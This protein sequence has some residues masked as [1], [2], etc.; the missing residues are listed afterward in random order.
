MKIWS[1]AFCFLN[2]YC[3]NHPLGSDGAREV[4]APFILVW[5]VEFRGTFWELNALVIICSLVRVLLWFWYPFILKKSWSYPI[6]ATGHCCLP[7][8]FCLVNI[9]TGSEIWLIRKKKKKFQL[10]N[11]KERNQGIN[12]YGYFFFLIY[13][14][15]LYHKGEV[16]WE[17]IY[18]VSSGATQWSADFLLCFY[19]PGAMNVLS[20]YFY[21]T[22]WKYTTKE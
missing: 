13:T 17:K 2:K 15:H 22:L 21:F 4:L 10:K 6:P 3:A 7:L 19:A 20:I 12:N 8:H 1:L 14:E 5:F 16:L 9:S 18:R 11:W